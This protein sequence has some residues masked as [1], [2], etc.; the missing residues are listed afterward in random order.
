VNH[1]SLLGFIFSAHWQFGLWYLFDFTD[2]TKASCEAVE[3]AA[4]GP[5]GHVTAEAVLFGAVPVVLQDCFP[6][7]TE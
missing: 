4:T 1:I 5:A 7:E 6:V 3:A 2:P